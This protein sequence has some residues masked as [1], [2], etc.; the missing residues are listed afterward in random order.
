MCY[1]KKDCPF[2]GNQARVEKIYPGGGVVATVYSN[3]GPVSDVKL[4][5]CDL[6]KMKVVGEDEVR[7]GE[8]NAVYFTLLSW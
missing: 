8:V 3:K 6:E 2:L 1:I 7:R 4:H 5:I